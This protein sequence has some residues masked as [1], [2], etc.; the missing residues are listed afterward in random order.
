MPPVIRSRV[1]ST[2]RSTALALLL[3]SACWTLGLRLTSPR[4]STAAAASHDERQSLLDAMEA[5]QRRAQDKLRLKGYDAP[6]YLGYTLK[7]T[8]AADVTARFGALYDRDR[9]TGRQLYVEVRV[10]DY[11]FDNSVPSA[12]PV[13]QNENAPEDAYEAKTDAPIDNDPVALRA[14]LWLLTDQTYKRALTALLKKKAKRIQETPGEMADVPSF[15]RE[16]AGRHVDPA[17]ELVWDSRGEQLARRLSARFRRS[18]HILDATVKV[19]GRRLTRIQVSTEGTRLITEDLLY[20]VQVDA[21]ARAPDGAL[22]EH[23]KHIYARTLEALGDPATL[24]RTVDT[25]IS[26][27][28]ALRKA[29]VLD[30]FTGPAILEGEATGVFFHE[31]IGHRLEGERQND[32][33]EGRT[34]KGQLGQAIMPTFLSLVD[35]PTTERYGAT[36]LNGN[37]RFDDEGVRARPAVLIENGVLR[38][39]L[40]SRTPIKGFA[41]SNGHGR[42]AGSRDPIA[43]M[44]NTMVRSSRTVTRAKLEQMLIEEAR[45]QGKPYGLVIRDII[46]GSTNTA[47][48]GYQAFKGVPRLVYKV[49]ARTG[50]RTLVR[51]VEMVG[52]PL[53]SINKIVA[54]G[55]VPEVFNGYCGAESGYVPVSTVAP[56]VLM[57]ELE[58]QRNQRGRERPPIMSPPWTIS[59][60]APAR[61]H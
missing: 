12:D 57:R 38:G 30:P 56:P 19:S 16:P 49:D 28:E 60:R 61:P 43:R 15:S 32:E 11:K 21:A 22:L 7:A 18:P 35:D 10:G 17:R 53:T 25:L 37:Y 34:F 31:A 55:D 24:E 41:H 50:V 45:R 9:Q 8:D 1:A 23:S 6:Y 20:G 4:L 40:L 46:G 3:G 44:G 26:E 29:P 13:A 2:V 52:T 36:A 39:F 58:L 59:G 33:K 48:F 54:T 51:G 5:E 14:G 42:A 27:L 47:S